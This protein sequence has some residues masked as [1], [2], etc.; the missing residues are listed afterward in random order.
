MKFKAG[1]VLNLMNGKNFYRI[2]T[3]LAFT[4]FNQDRGVTE[5]NKY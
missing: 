5:L 3:L 1:G 4:T 2:F